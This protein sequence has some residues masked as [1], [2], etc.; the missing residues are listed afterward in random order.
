MRETVRGAILMALLIGAGHI[1]AAPP[2]DIPLRKL[3]QQSDLI[4]VAEVVSVG[5]PTELELQ[6]PYMDKPTQTLCRRYELAVKRVIKGKIRQGKDT[7][8]SVLARSL[9]ASVE[10]RPVPPPPGLQLPWLDTGSSYILL[11]RSLPGRAEYFL[12]DYPK[13]YQPAN[14]ANVKAIMKKVAMRPVEKALRFLKLM[15]R[16]I[17][18][19]QAS[20]LILD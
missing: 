12:P 8:V 17:F 2:P 13:N 20:T 9:R 4:I 7:P 16:L 19:S 5:E 15:F 11:L 18:Q 10:G 6:L 1:Y 3:V 14:K